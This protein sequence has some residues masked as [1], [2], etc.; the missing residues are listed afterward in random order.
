M[1]FFGRPINLVSGG[2]DRPVVAGVALRWSHVTEAAVAVL[3]VVPAHK[4]QDPVTG[5]LQAFET[6]VRIVRPVLAGAK[7]RL[8]KRCHR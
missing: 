3:V 6:R 5:R 1:A 4:R 7:Q 8:G 2:Q